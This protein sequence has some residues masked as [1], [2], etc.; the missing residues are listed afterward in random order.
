MTLKW[1]TDKAGDALW[2]GGE[3]LGCI[4]SR[5]SYGGT[6]KGWRVLGPDFE[7][8]ADV[9]PGP[10][11]RDARMEARALLEGSRGPMPTAQQLLEA[12]S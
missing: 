11:L 3:Y 2:D 7:H 8:I 10:L 1:K 9:P 12:T 4:Y 5:D 6:R